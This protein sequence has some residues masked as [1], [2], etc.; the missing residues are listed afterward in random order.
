MPLPLP[1]E[2]EALRKKFHV[3]GMPTVIIMDSG[4]R[5]VKRLTGFVKPEEF[6]EYLKLA[7]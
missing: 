7:Q 5:E 2:N 4:G 6:S 3:V 1:I